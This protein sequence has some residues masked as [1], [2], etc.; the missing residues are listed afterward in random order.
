M[1]AGLFTRLCGHAATL[2]S[3]VENLLFPSLLCVIASFYSFYT[4]NGVW[5]AAG[6]CM[7]PKDGAVKVHPQK[8]GK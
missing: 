8:G 3:S 7:N 5:C 4:V 2:I 6:C 1:A